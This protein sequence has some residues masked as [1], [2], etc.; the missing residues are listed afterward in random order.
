MVPEDAGPVRPGPD[1]P[2]QERPP[3]WGARRRREARA[4]GDPRP[5]GAS[6]PEAA[7]LL[8]AEG[9]L[10]LAL[11]RRG[12]AALVGEA[13]AGHC[14]PVRLEGGVL[15]VRADDGAW[16]AELR[17]HAVT[18]VRRAHGLVPGIERL[19]VGVGARNE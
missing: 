14:W 15:V 3:V 6:L 2:G 12:W 19:S 13:L 10:E 11:V 18:V 8:G 1:R 9:A 4:G 17:F 7:R 5:V 16:A